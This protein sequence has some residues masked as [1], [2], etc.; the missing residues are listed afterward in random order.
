MLVGGTAYL[1]YICRIQNRI[2]KRV[3]RCT[4][5]TLSLKRSTLRPVWK[6]LILDR[7]GQ[8]PYPRHRDRL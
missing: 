5:C 6:D 1:F 8:W 4:V 7:C 2:A 3:V